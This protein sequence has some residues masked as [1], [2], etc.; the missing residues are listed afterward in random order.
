[1]L[2]DGPANSPALLF[3]RRPYL[4]WGRMQDPEL[5]VDCQASKRLRTKHITLTRVRGH[6]MKKLW[7]VIAGLT[8]LIV[9]TTRV[10]HAV[11]VTFFGED[12]NSPNAGEITRIT[13]HPQADNAR[14]AFLASLAT[15][16][17]E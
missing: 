9:G 16:N 2:T 6:R 11:L 10:G 3:P 4:Q 8:L 1:M 7:V 13:S 15:A 17:T 12:L 14:A 5:A